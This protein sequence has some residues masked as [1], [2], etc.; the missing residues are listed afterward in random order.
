MSMHTQLVFFIFNCFQCSYLKQLQ[1]VIKKGVCLDDH[2]PQMTTHSFRNMKYK[3]LSSIQWFNNLNK[4]STA[5]LLSGSQTIYCNTEYWII[6]WGLSYLTFRLK[7]NDIMV[8]RCADIN[9]WS[10]ISNHKISI[11]YRYRNDWC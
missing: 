7:S 3:I 2:W 9:L 4:M 11:L 1:L 10:L 5:F 8:A 6:E